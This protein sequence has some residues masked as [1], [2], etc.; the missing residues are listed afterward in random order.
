VSED[1]SSRL[2]AWALLLDVIGTAL[3]AAGLYFLIG[4]RTPRAIAIV[5]LVAGPLMML[6][7]VVV[8]VSRAGQ[9]RKG[10]D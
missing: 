8:L 6:P 10:G 9:H 2:P 4:E 7:M 3:L 5:L 1:R